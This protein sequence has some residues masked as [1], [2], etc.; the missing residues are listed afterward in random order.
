VTEA[1]N[2]AEA[3]GPVKVHSIAGEAAS[4][5]L[6]Y[7]CLD[8]LLLPEETPQFQAY[9]LNFDALPD[10]FDE[11]ASGITFL[12]Q[13]AVS[14]LPL[15]AAETPGFSVFATSLGQYWVLE[16]TVANEPLGAAFGQPLHAYTLAVLQS[17]SYKSPFITTQELG[18]YS[19]PRE[20]Q[21]AVLVLLH[22]ALAA[23][24]SQGLTL[25]FNPPACGIPWGSSPLRG[26]PEDEKALSAHRSGARFTQAG[27]IEGRPYPLIPFS[28]F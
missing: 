19:L 5:S 10:F 20:K 13:T 17:S 22:E 3:L 27:L 14:A 23:F 18:S 9:A 1:T 26:V 7:H 12:P 11:E 15:E 4:H 28:P 8:E 21:S 2:N 25:V 24:R 16:L 6:G